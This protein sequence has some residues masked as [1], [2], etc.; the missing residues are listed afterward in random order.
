MSGYFEMLPPELLQDI[1]DRLDFREKVPLMRCSKTLLAYLQ[2][3]VFSA[4]IVRDMAMHWAISN[5]CM[6]LIRRLVEEHGAS[7]SFYGGTVVGPVEVRSG[8]SRPVEHGGMR[9]TRY[10]QST[11]L[12]VLKRAPQGKGALDTFVEL[13][14]TLYPEECLRSKKDYLEADLDETEIHSILNKQR[15]TLL[16][17]IASMPTDK[18][19]VMDKIAFIRFFYE[20]GYRT[21]PDIVGTTCNI[22]YTLPRLIR[23]DN[24]FRVVKLVLQEEANVAEEEEG[25]EAKLSH[26][27][28]TSEAGE[29][30]GRDDQ[31]GQGDQEVKQSKIPLVDRPETYGPRGALV[32]PLSAAILTGSTKIFKLL[33][34]HGA[35]IHGPKLSFQKVGPTAHAL[36]IPIFAAAYVMAGRKTHSAGR[37]WLEECHAKGANINHMAL[38]RLSGTHKP[39]KPVE[40]SLSYYSQGMRYPATHYFWAT[41]MDVFIDCLPTE[42]LLKKKDDKNPEGVDEDD[43]EVMDDD[44][45]FSAAVSMNL[46]NDK[47]AVADLGSLREPPPPKRSVLEIGKNG[48]EGPDTDTVMGNT[49]A[50]DNDSKSIMYPGPPTDASLDQ[51]RNLRRVVSPLTLE[52]LLDKISVSGLAYPVAYSYAELLR[53]HFSSGLSQA[54]RL[55]SK[56]DGPSPET[57]YPTWPSGPE[58]TGRRTLAMLLLCDEDLTSQSREMQRYIVYV[59]RRAD[60]LFLG[61]V[62]SNLEQIFSGPRWMIQKDYPYLPDPIADDIEMRQELNEVDEIS[63]ALSDSPEDQEW[64]Q[65]YTAARYQK[66]PATSATSSRWTAMHEICWM[67]NRRLYLRDLWIAR[68]G[69]DDARVAE[70]HLRFFRQPESTTTLLNAL[71]SYGLSV[72][73]ETEDGKT[74]ISILT[75]DHD[76]ALRPDSKEFLGKLANFMTARAALVAF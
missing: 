16:R 14:A 13:G 45:S 3:Q 4:K 21:R 69:P 33:L 38:C 62:L 26:T 18:E 28:K 67:W 61:N 19:Y 68:N 70:G 75:N 22:A 55:M 27:N 39:Y 41:P 32:S 25:K 49:D 64:L 6:T 11:L 35:D 1:L 73:Y 52:V 60:L 34:Q 31:E 50:V 30:N 57:R 53:E 29:P 37:F 42:Y 43:D 76:G 48:K 63:L 23:S 59:Q 44:I 9:L 12:A 74:P 54:A 65:K 71:I 8:N 56:Y 72:S 15:Y 7:P 2:P 58:S 47:G 51:W 17:R 40:M 66:S 5:G 36:H 10:P 20:Q 46:F 24:D